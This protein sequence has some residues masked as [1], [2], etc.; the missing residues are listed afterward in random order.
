MASLVSLLLV[1]LISCPFAI[2]T[3]IKFG[4]NPDKQNVFLPHS[5]IDTNGK[6]LRSMIIHASL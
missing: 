5:D 2:V 1:M 3:A 4:E 6:V